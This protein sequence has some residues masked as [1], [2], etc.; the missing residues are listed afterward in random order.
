MGTRYGNPFVDT[1]AVQESG[2]DSG[3]TRTGF[4]YLRLPQQSGQYEVCFSARYL[5]VPPTNISTNLDSK[6]VW[7]KLRTCGAPQRFPF[8]VS[9]ESLV[10]SVR[11]ATPSTWGPVR[12]AETDVGRWFDTPLSRR[13]SSRPSDPIWADGDSFRIVPA[14][15][16]TAPDAASTRG[17]ATLGTMAG[18]GCWHQGGT[19]S[20]WVEEGTPEPAGSFDLGDDPFVPQ[21]DRMDEADNMNVTYG[22]AYIPAA[23]PDPPAGGAY[24]LVLRDLDA[25]QEQNPESGFVSPASVAAGT[26]VTL[27]SISR[28][29]GATGTYVRGRLAYPVGYVTL[30]NE[31]TA[32]SER[33][34]VPLYSV[35][36][37]VGASDGGWRTPSW[38]GGDG[39]WTAEGYPYASL[40]APQPLVPGGFSAEASPTLVWWA[41]NDTRGGVFGPV[42][43]TSRNSTIDTRPWQA[44]YTSDGSLLEQG[45]AVRV[46]PSYR[47]CDWP[48][49][50]WEVEKGLAG[51]CAD[52]GDAECE[53][54]EVHAAGAGTCL[55]AEADSSGTA[56]GV[57]QLTIP[58]PHAQSYPSAF[59]V[60][61]RNA[62]ANWR[63]IPHDSHWSGPGSPLQVSRTSYSPLVALAPTSLSVYAPE[64]R[65]GEESLLYFTSTESA[66]TA[67]GCTWCP[68]LRGDTVRLVPTLW[69]VAAGRMARMRNSVRPS[70]LEDYDVLSVQLPN[71][72]AHVRS[73]RT[74]EV[75]VVQLRDLI[76]VPRTCAL[77]P[78]A[79]DPAQSDIWLQPVCPVSGTGLPSA[80][81]ITTT[82]CAYT[83]GSKQLCGGVWCNDASARTRDMYALTAVTPDV[84]DDIV[85][86]DNVLDSLTYAVATVRIPEPQE[87][88]PFGGE[89]LQYRLCYRQMGTAGWITLD[90]N[91]SVT[92]G[93]TTWRPQQSPVRDVVPAPGEVLL[94]G[95]VRMFTVGEFGGV[96][97]LRAKLVASRGGG[98]DQC[99][100]PPGGS[101]AAP[102]SSVSEG[103]DY[104]PSAP[105]A[106]GASFWLLV[107]QQQG[108]YWLCLQTQEGA[109]THL[110][111]W[112]R[113][114]PYQVQDNG[115][116]WYTPLSSYPT[117]QALLQIHIA[118]CHYDRGSCGPPWA[119]SVA[120]V[121]D[122]TAGV[123]AGKVVAVNES[124]HDGRLGSSASTQGPSL[125]V[126]QEGGSVDGA[127]NLGPGDGAAADA[128]LT[129]T[130]PATSADRSVEYRV[131]VFSAFAAIGGRR[132]WVEVEQAQGGRWLERHI[133]VTAP[134][135]TWQGGVLTEAGNTGTRPAFWT[136][137]AVVK[138]WTL[139]DPLRP[140]WNMLS[141]V[142][143]KA[144]EVALSGSITRYVSHVFSPWDHRAGF[145][146]ETWPGSP[147]AGQ[148]SARNNFKLVRVAGPTSRYPA[149]SSGQ[150]WVWQDTAG[151]A[152]A[153]GCG[154]T[155]VAGTE[156]APTL[157]G[158]CKAAACPSIRVVSGQAELYF[159]FPLDPGEYIVCYRLN[160]TKPWLLLPSSNN[161]TSLF[162]VPSYL[163]FQVTGTT[164]VSVHDTRTGWGAREG[165]SAA[166]WCPDPC[167][168]LRDIIYLANSSGM[169]PL[170]PV[171]QADVVEKPAG[172]HAIRS[173][174][175]NEV[176][177]VQAGE[178]FRV[179]PDPAVR[180]SESALRFCL[181][182][183]GAPSGAVER[184][185]R[186]GTV[187]Q[188]W[189]R[190]TPQSG[191]GTAFWTD[192]GALDSMSAQPQIEF[193]STLRFST[194]PG[195]GGGTYATSQTGSTVILPGGAFASSSAVVQAG[196]PVPIVVRA[197][198]KGLV[199][200]QG[201][202]PVYIATCDDAVTW[203]DLECPNPK[204]PER[205]GGMLVNKN[206]FHVSFNGSC[207]KD[208]QQLMPAS[209]DA[210]F[211]ITINS[212]CP[213]YLRNEGEA[214]RADPQLPAAGCGFRFA[215]RGRGGN[216][217]VVYSN[218]VWLNVIAAAPDAVAI[219]G[220]ELPPGCP[221]S[222]APGCAGVHAY[223]RNS[224]ACE[225]RIQAR[226]GGPFWGAALG[227]IQ[228]GLGQSTQEQQRNFSTG[229]DGA[230]SRT[231]TWPQ[232]GVYIFS[233]QLSLRGGE[234]VGFINV[235][236]TLKHSS[237]ATDATSQ[238]R[239]MVSRPRPALVR[240]VSLE[241]LDTAPRS[242][243][244]TVNGTS[245]LSSSEELFRELDRPPTTTWEPA[246]GSDQAF[247][248]PRTLQ[249]AIDGGHAE[250]L[251][252]YLLRYQVVTAGDPTPQP[253]WGSLEPISDLD[254]WEVMANLTGP[255]NNRLLWM[256][257]LVHPIFVGGAPARENL[258]EGAAARAMAA[259]PITWS[260]PLSSA[261][262]PAGIGATWVLPLRFV[263]GWGCSRLNDYRV[264]PTI[265]RGKG[266]ELTLWL[267]H[268]STDG[269][270]SARLRTPVRIPA[271]ALRV[272]VTAAVAADGT[273]S[274]E[275]TVPGQRL[276]V[277]RTL[278]EGIEVTVL[279]GTWTSDT[280]FLMDEFHY[281]DIFA[282]IDS[283]N[284]LQTPDG[285]HMTDAEL[286]QRRPGRH[287]P[288]VLDSGGTTGGMWAA[289]WTLRTNKP[290]M[291]CTL[292]FHSD[293]GSGPDSA[294]GVLAGVIQVNLTDD[295][296]RL[297]CPATVS[298]SSGLVEWERGSSPAMGCADQAACTSTSMEFSLA[299]EPVNVDD[300][301][302][303]WPRWWVFLDLVNG[304]RVDIG[305]WVPIAQAGYNISQA[306]ATGRRALAQRMA[307]ADPR[308]EVTA[309]SSCRTRVVFDK[310]SFHGVP[311]KVDTRIQLTAHSVG[312]VYDSSVPGSALTR[313]TNLQCVQV[314][315]V[316]PLAGSVSRHLHVL[317]FSGAQPL[318]EACTT[319]KCNCD[320]WYA[321]EGSWLA[322]QP[323]SLTVAF[324][325]STV[326][327]GM[328]RDN[329]DRNIT[330][331]YH[332]LV[333][334]WTCPDVGG[335]GPCT[336]AKTELR[337]TAHD[338]LGLD[339][340]G[341]PRWYTF[342]NLSGLHFTTSRVRTWTAPGGQGTIQLTVGPLSPRPV[343]DV[344]FEVCAAQGVGGS[345]RQTALSDPPCISIRF[346]VIVPV[347]AQ[348]DSPHIGIMRL[349]E[350][351]RRSTVLNP[352]IPA[353]P[354]NSLACGRD[355]SV[356]ELSVAMYYFRGSVAYLM[357]D[358]PFTYS[359][360]HNAPTKPTL[361]DARN[362]SRRGAV[363]YESSPLQL[364]PPA[365]Y[366][367]ESSPL[368]TFRFSIINQADAAQFTV[369]QLF[370]D[371]SEGSF[372]ST[373]AYYSVARPPEAPYSTWRISPSV[374][375]DGECPSR[376]RM[377]ASLNGYLTYVSEPGKGWS[378][379]AGA[380][381]GVP[382]PVQ[383][384]VDA[385]RGG[386][387]WGY[388]SS[389]TA[390]DMAPSP[391]GCRDGGNPRLYRP[392]SEL[393][394]IDGDLGAFDQVSTG[395]VSNGVSTTWVVLSDRCEA[396]VLRLRLCP[397][398]VQR[399]V[400]CTPTPDTVEGPPGYTLS[401]TSQ[402]FTVTAAFPDVAI[403][404]SQSFPA[405][406]HNTLG[407]SAISVGE[408]FTL[409][410]TPARLFGGSPTFWAMTG[411]LEDGEMEAWVMNKWAGSASAE[412][413]QRVRYGNGGF[414]RAT[415]TT[416]EPCLVGARLFSGGQ[417]LVPTAGGSLRFVFAR[418]CSACEIWVHYRFAATGVTKAFALRD[419]TGDII[420]GEVPIPA[421]A[422]KAFRV[423]T[424]GTRWIV[425]GVRPPAARRRTPFALTVLWSD[426]NNIPSWS[427]NP[428]ATFHYPVEGIGGNGDGGD[429]TIASP[430]NPVRGQRAEEVT[431][432]NGTAMITVRAS[433][434]C[435]SC[436]M[437]FAGLPHSI[438]ILTDPTQII[439][440]PNETK[441]H[442]PSAAERGITHSWEDSPTSTTFQ[443]SAY[444]A[445][446]YGDRAYT[447]GGPSFQAWYPR[448]R[449]PEPPAARFS[450]LPDLQRHS[451]PD[452][453]ALPGE[454]V[455]YPQPTLRISAGR[456]VVNGLP[457]GELCSES[458]AQP[459]GVS[460]TLEGAP[461]LRLPLVLELQAVQGGKWSSLPLP[462]RERGGAGPP[463]V[464][465][466]PSPTDAR[467]AA[468]GKPGWSSSS[469]EP[470][471][472][473]PGETLILDVFAVRDQRTMN[474]SASPGDMWVTDAPPGLG[475]SSYVDCDTT[476]SDMSAYCIVDTNC[477][478][479]CP[480]CVFDSGASSAAEPFYGGRAALKVLFKRGVTCGGPCTG[481][482]QWVA[483]LPAELGGRSIVVPL[484]LK[485]LPAVQWNWVPTSTFT[486]QRSLTAPE[487]VA[488]TVPEAEVQITMEAWTETGAGWQEAHVSVTP[489]SLAGAAL[490]GSPLRCWEQLAPA[491]VHHSD[492]SSRIT[493]TGTFRALYC[494][495]ALANSIGN[496]QSPL[497]I[498][499]SSVVPV[500][501]VVDYGL[502]AYRQV[503]NYSGLTALTADG[504][505]AAA[506]G[507][508]VVLRLLTVNSSGAVVVGD[509]NSF[510]VLTATRPGHQ[511]IVV[512]TTAVAGVLHFEL[513]FQ[514]PTLG[515][516]WD[517]SVTAWFPF[518][519]GGR[520][521]F[522]SPS[523]GQIPVVRR[524]HRLQVRIQS[525]SPSAANLS[526]IMLP[527]VRDPGRATVRWVHGYPMRLLLTAVDGAEVPQVVSDP[528]GQGHDADIMFAP[529]DIPCMEPDLMRR[530]GGRPWLELTCL[531]RHPLTERPGPN[532]TV[533]LVGSPGVIVGEC[534]DS[535]EVPGCGSGGWSVCM[536]PPSV[537]DAVQVLVDGIWEVGILS[538]EPGADSVANVTLD[539]SSATVKV[540][541]DYVFPRNCALREPTARRRLKLVAGAGRI[542][543]AWY[544]GEQEGPMQ[545]RLETHDF[546]K[547]YS[548]IGELVM[549][550]MTSLALAGAQ[551]RPGQQR[552]IEC[553]FPT[554]AAFRSAPPNST[555]DA[556]VLAFTEFE[557]SVLI[558]DGRGDVVVGDDFSLIRISARC[559][560]PETVIR[561]G[562]LG[563]V[564]GKQVNTPPGWDVARVV[565]GRANFTKLGFRGNC[566]NARLQFDCVADPSVDL[567]GHCRTLWLESVGAMI[568]DQ[569]AMTPTPPVPPAGAVDQPVVVLRLGETEV[570]FNEQSR[571]AFQEVML[572]SIRAKARY[573][574]DV[575]EVFLIHL[576]TVRRTRVLAGLTEED[577]S[578]PAVCRR[579][580]YSAL[581]GIGRH[582]LQAPSATPSA[583]PSASPVVTALTEGPTGA[584]AATGAPTAVAT[585]APTA[586]ASPDNPT[587]SPSA[588]GAPPS[589]SPL[590]ANATAAP[591]AAS[592]AAPASGGSPP[593]GAPAASGSSG[594]PTSAQATATS[595]PTAATSFPTDLRAP[596]DLMGD[597]PSLRPEDC[598]AVGCM[599]VAEIAVI[600]LNPQ[601]AALVAD[602]FAAVRAALDDPTSP[603][604]QVYP[605]A[606]LVSEELPAPPPEDEDIARPA[607]VEAPFAT[608]WRK[609][610]EP[611]LED[612]G[613]LPSAAGHA[614]VGLLTG[615]G[616]V[617][618]TTAIC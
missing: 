36:Y 507:E 607:P 381:T 366:V 305:G 38:A 280:E 466:T 553:D 387:A 28:H 147:G 574:A 282:L 121:F 151:E 328:W 74:Q 173:S 560:D 165:A 352:G 508:P 99:T 510:A 250:S 114:G 244:A 139:A 277:Q 480:G 511:S 345:F 611:P 408:L 557:V 278:R 361:V 573:P 589:A 44:V 134:A 521:D 302:T 377:A 304:V 93:G 538:G 81:G 60:C 353:E 140:S 391:R 595:R 98:N 434:A 587:E 580:R 263:G 224:V 447:V 34:V 61:Y 187:Y 265:P 452:P 310:L 488:L 582:L 609:P 252:P 445:D 546:A 418:T 122:T 101:E 212:V 532:G 430:A 449:T 297:K 141:T 205:T 350:A 520:R 153:R 243:S 40:A 502:D 517:V 193:D 550:R 401:Q 289:R 490:A 183:S 284:G 12:F 555:V 286:P 273:R 451:P 332:G 549:Q 208:G 364:S 367:S 11:D 464:T 39:V 318:C 13:R 130:M 448:W 322:D 3:G 161:V 402:P 411:G 439:T 610:M 307:L 327:E 389:I 90:N 275:P 468:R 495:L 407:G 17:R 231:S 503:A 309:P 218:A 458:G 518:A 148:L 9:P 157:A 188:L 228:L 15:A 476:L 420:K 248:S 94:G 477:S 487:H 155:G 355:P 386:R 400:D 565:N 312:A 588:G 259:D 311:P 14:M 126:G 608:G 276:S 261:S 415:E 1:L 8:S 551:C 600:V 534:A 91:S 596:V 37:R 390:I 473:V 382:F 170:P 306:G 467:I 138:R 65:S 398:G 225:I 491:K 106:G 486:M 142:N 79:W 438:A 585:G 258:D 385:E 109:F 459:G 504:T 56:L 285:A 235:A 512:N 75:R 87:A 123:D 133:P 337:S 227:E 530:P 234:T 552:G 100:N 384:F 27:L 73:R 55:G 379:T 558:L 497:V 287:T 206:P 281:G 164:N 279:P 175:S 618:T 57:F 454:R 533:I 423:V 88:V 97:T 257:K 526:S 202:F 237:R 118:R 528:A 442:D 180:P 241:A 162:T 317:E 104:V 339:Y 68:C 167:H 590:A 375:V 416:G 425:A 198:G 211:Y 71:R 460:V 547:D 371:G 380:V 168:P 592:T 63:A 82:P 129:T 196:V 341:I 262:M 156:N 601:S 616:V 253:G 260:G 67:A 2:P 264:I 301:N 41:A 239:L 516:P 324:Y 435:F 354:G 478:F 410:V 562:L 578:N 575:K 493:F 326:L 531:P 494:R 591:A 501:V 268:R 245:V 77:S 47:P 270:L 194:Y 362:T 606:L 160:E 111:S 357:Y 567:L 545:F 300:Q 58:T 197:A 236:V 505:P 52:G 440:V 229:I 602:T 144:I 64:V 527:D 597:D 254:G 441:G 53:A 69:A 4:A 125:H 120:E 128:V 338:E 613:G 417:R 319:A 314:I 421:S 16:H 519:G 336:T 30:A 23:F 191:A 219:N 108:Q 143:T 346:W 559:D 95:E 348:M 535:L 49:H 536:A 102:A 220:V 174:A 222:G 103:F 489:G 315:E 84:W 564:S 204:A 429:W 409:Q 413:S 50:S 576:C 496:A 29:T 395:R 233:P 201:G 540:S 295:T 444:L 26:V 251:V 463:L 461:A 177:A 70:I 293:W 475:V 242:Q 192:S 186:P 221:E 137:A 43:L 48:G 453:I 210:T 432:V 200:P 344:R 19:P 513:L 33:F 329:L 42:T 184:L 376:Q 169:C 571:A 499:A 323:L 325:N 455:A 539:A 209:G 124:C 223:C 72:T 145:Y 617:I 107:P 105:L 482:C 470:V 59:R 368:V 127:R 343:R 115:V 240:I 457:N 215:T 271:V 316:R 548:F 119:A 383:A 431:A 481:F 80:S 166:W 51:E 256:T 566:T 556:A 269:L 116:R 446:D 542:S 394:L 232:G 422:A 85:P 584:A 579:W 272:D 46:V 135:S 303:V 500:A 294:G 342:G 479:N 96:N 172:W 388:P 544:M 419:Y 372:I 404:T 396:C 349:G 462:T 203:D 92:G 605:Q 178:A 246:A 524:A 181:Y 110:T 469:G 290:C 163:E 525:A 32:V 313:D 577:K 255:Q 604:R 321:E 399:L 537:G 89:L 249:V 403:V 373:Q 492:H 436:S 152:R 330:V 514:E 45:G 226:W 132:T 283:S 427:G 369:M 298:S 484:R 78:D 392:R 159:T 360:R 5:R 465:W 213:G 483:V 593:T 31:T 334:L 456:C 21:Q 397:R 340:E 66:L 412:I 274:L 358:Q 83:D 414:I 614:A 35:C 374:Q 424:C 54:C 426:A 370:S 185:I 586:A 266:C 176:A 347:A 182:K 189:N 149:N 292:S 356:V 308:C 594:A 296:V 86:G 529:V 599:S 393:T 433:R 450:A 581:S 365:S 506:V 437:R 158:G 331:R 333:P 561:V 485:V 76:P 131:C 247:S 583:N 207:T 568:I 515:S 543:P 522:A 603:I 291:M 18:A 217:R 230:V 190:G 572:D 554:G 214:W 154:G 471:D 612:L 195:P 523:V 474:S 570:N 7:R 498:A 10:W 335:T 569:S 25:R 351:L 598:G 378:Y 117:N 267:R 443:F 24:W 171:A 405:P 472:V 288:G 216:D 179:P 113:V 238:F 22:S 136:E 363:L 509:Y 563:G 541:I 62:S 428:T 6:P 406:T 146:V 299:V 359:V 199:V 112:R 150:G 615:I 20:G 320:M